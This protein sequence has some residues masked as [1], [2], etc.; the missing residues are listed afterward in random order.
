MVD[1]SMAIQ[2]ITELLNTLIRVKVN[3]LNYWLFDRTIW[4][5]LVKFSNKLVISKS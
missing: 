2:S 5:F 4:H 3:L 1:S